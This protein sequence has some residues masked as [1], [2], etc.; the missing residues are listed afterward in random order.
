MVNILVV[1]PHP[2]DQEIGMGGAIAKFV[3][4]GHD[5]LLLDITNGE[6]TPHGSVEI[7]AAEAAAAAEILGVRRVNIGFPNRYLEHNLELRHAIAGVIRAHQAEM[8]FTPYFEDAHPDHLAVTKCVIDA[9]FAAK[10]TKVEGGAE[11][12]WAKAGPAIYPK[13]L[14]FYYAMH[15][16]KVHNPNFVIDISGYEEQ[17][18][19]SIEA[20]HSQFVIP[21][22]NRKV[23]EGIK[24]MGTYFGSRIGTAA[25]EP[26]F[27][28]EPLA[29]GSLDGLVM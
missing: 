26:F 21:E 5:V 7:R 20:Y 15:L 19:A 11:A 6:P 14:F 10:L 24:A 18:H 2:D 23:F 22:K 3:A 9:R 1:G 13:W 25:G 29:L 28:Q 4:Q 27:T 16:R 12:D 8:V 17:K